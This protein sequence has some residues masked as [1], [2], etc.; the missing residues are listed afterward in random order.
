MIDT[1]HIRGASPV[2]FFINVINCF[3]SARLIGSAK[4]LTNAL[5]LIAVGLVLFAAIACL[6]RFRRRRD[7]DYSRG[8]ELPP[9][10]IPNGYADEIQRILSLEILDFISS[11]L[12]TPPLCASTSFRSVP[13][14]ACP[15]R[16]RRVVPNV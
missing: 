6:L 2:A 13:R 11:A 16:D 4:S 14:K 7:S 3:A 12:Q 8:P 15:K 9:G 1:P 5:T 10:Q